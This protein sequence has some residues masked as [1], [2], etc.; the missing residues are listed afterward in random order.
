MGLTV[1]EMLN[2]NMFSEFKVLAGNKGLD[3]QIQG[4]AILDAPDGYKWTRGKELVISSGYLLSK[5]QSLFREI[6]KSNEFKLMSGMGIKER[7]INEIPPDILEEFNRNNIPLILIPP[8]T[9]WMDIMNQLNVIVMNKSIRQFNIG[10]VNPGNY[11]D[12]T[13]QVRKIERILS[14]IEKEMG[15]TGM[16]YDMNK[17]KAYYSSNKFLKL[18]DKFNTTDF[19]EPPIEVTQEVLCDNLKMIR[20]RY[21][22][23]RYEIPYSWITIPIT[24]MGKVKSYFVLLEATG[25]IDYFDQFAIRIGFLLLQSL[26]EQLLFL[27]SIGDFGFEKFISDIIYGNLDDHD[28]INTRAVDINIDATKKFYCMLIRQTNP[29]LTG[30]Q[31]KDEIN[32]TINNAFFMEDVRVAFINENKILMLIPKEDSSIDKYQLKLIQEN[33][34]KIQEKL[35]KS[36]LESKFIFGLYDQDALIYDLKKSYD[37][38][39]QVIRIGS[40]IFTENRFVKH[41]QLGVFSWIHVDEVELDKMVKDMDKILKHNDSEE[42][43]E[44][45]KMYLNCKMNY[46]LTAKNLF[47]HINTV[48]KRISHINNLLEIDLDDPINRLKLELLLLIAK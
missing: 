38:A 48:R 26:Y 31:Y 36:I 29:N 47:I 37:K 4:I 28:R 8:S 42:L 34:M 1:R 15:F 27:E 14:Q 23:E 33:T 35:E 17:N 7:F 3:N 41:S 2:N 5:D 19:W 16:L 11:T 46:S 22:D 40:R 25:L 45:L 13:Y 44:T 30:S 18:A 21:L 39:N 10:R 43:I 24:V 6:T 20:H 32:R 12:L 9:A